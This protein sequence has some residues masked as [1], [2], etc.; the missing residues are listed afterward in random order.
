MFVFIQEKVHAI[1]KVEN[2][3]LEALFLLK[4]SEI[5]I[6][7]GQVSE[8]YMIHITGKDK[9]NSIIRNNFDWRRVKR[10]QFG[11]GT[12]FSKDATYANDLANWNAGKFLSLQVYE[13]IMKLV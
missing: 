5:N 10:G 7:H 9:V 6:R 4:K 11:R 13:I 3:F 8:Q 1:K 2:N 12:S